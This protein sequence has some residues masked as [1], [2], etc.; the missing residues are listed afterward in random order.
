[1]KTS[2]SRV[3]SYTMKSCAWS[4][5]LFSRTVVLPRARSESGRLTLS[6]HDREIKNLVSKHNLSEEDA[7][8]LLKS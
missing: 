5:E 8:E 1:L 4:E 6:D 7:V 2:I 3:V